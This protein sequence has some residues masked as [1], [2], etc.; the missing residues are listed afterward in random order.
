MKDK[1]FTNE[2]FEEISLHDNKIH[3]V[4]F[5]V[6]HEKFQSDVVFDIDYIVEWECDSKCEF[7]VAPATL[8]FH[9]VT[10]LNLSI[11][12]GDSGFQNSVSGPFILEL[13]REPAETKMRIDKYY[14]WEIVCN[15]E[16]HNISFGA[17]GFTMK[18]QSEPV[19]SDEQYLGVEE[20]QRLF[21]T[22]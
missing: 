6:D 20:R 18:L 5:C 9:N 1:I 22:L 21:R 8:R 16:K 2:N 3:G 4:Q 12:W 13:K 7:I 17:S 15:N 10:D 14:R 19:A 11:N